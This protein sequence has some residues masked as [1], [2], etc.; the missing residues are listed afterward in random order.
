M[1]SFS[2][3]TSVFIKRENLYTDIHM[4]VITCEAEGGDQGGASI[5]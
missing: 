4:G 3:M 1:D 5:C 2:N